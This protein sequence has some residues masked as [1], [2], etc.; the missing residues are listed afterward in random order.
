MSL[1]EL[2]STHG[3]AAIA[4][5]T[6]LEGETVLVLGGFAAHRGYLQLPW[7]VVCAFLGTLFGDQL[8]FYTGRTVGAHILEKRSHW[9]SKS[10]RVFDLLHRHRLLLV[11]GFRFLYGFR[12]ITPFLLGA[13]GMPPVFFLVLN[14]VGAFLWALVIGVM[15][16]M[17]GQALE[18][19]ISD[20]K[21]YE[22]W[23]FVALAATGAAVWLYHF[24]SRGKQSRDNHRRQSL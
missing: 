15:G 13:S 9:K 12:T 20:V 4:V 10:T 22:L 3:Y 5:G 1:E 17:V 2:I 7:V 16:Y 21:R 24:L 11:L 18:L 8:F 19:I 23:L 14:V 6:F